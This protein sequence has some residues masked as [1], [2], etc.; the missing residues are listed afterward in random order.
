MVKGKEIK[1]SLPFRSKSLVKQF[2]LSNGLLS[3]FER[4]KLTFYETAL[5]GNLS[6]SFFIILDK[7]FMSAFSDDE[8]QRNPAMFLHILNK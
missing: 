3:G 5:T 8:I 6:L 7:V 2:S 1:L 4:T